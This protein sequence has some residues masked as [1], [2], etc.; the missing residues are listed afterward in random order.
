MDKFSYVASA[1]RSFRNSS[2]G[3][4]GKLAKDGHEN[5]LRNQSIFA[6]DIDRCQLGNP[7]GG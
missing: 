1:R 5:G 6:S 7:I 4:V 2:G 3:A